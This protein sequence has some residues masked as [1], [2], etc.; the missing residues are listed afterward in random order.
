MG[1]VNRYDA[2]VVGGGH[3]GLVAAFYLARAGLKPIVL[4]R[5]HVTGGPC[6]P[7]EYFP[8]YRGAFTNS[9]GSLEP[10]IVRDMELERHGLKFVV[11]NPT[12]VHPF[13]GD[14][15]FIGWRDRERTDEV[16]ASFSKK[17]AVAYYQI[18]DFLNAFGAK[19]GV[20]LFKPPPSLHELVARMET[21]EDEANFSDIMFGSV[22]DFLDARLETE[23]IKALIALLAVMSN[24]VGPSTPG[25]P[26]QLLQRPMSLASNTV[27][28][29]HDPRQ[30]PLRGSTGLPLGGMGS[31]AR[32]MESALKEKGG[33]VRT[34]SAV[35]RI[36][37]R[38]GRVTGVALENGDEF[39]ADLVLSNLHPKTTLLGLT[40]R[41]FLPSKVTER[42]GRYVMRN[43]GFKVVLALDG[44]PRYA[45]AKTDEEAR[46]IGGCQFRIAPTMEYMDRGV[47]AARYGELHHYPM[48]W[49]LIPSVADPTMAP[50]GK[51]VMSVNIFHAPYH[52]RDGDWS[53]Q[54][55]VFG[56]RCID[57]LSQFMPN[58]KSLILQKRFWSPRDLESEFGLLEG[59]V[60]HGDMVP[61]KMFGFRPSPELAD[62]RTPINGLYHCGSGTWPGGTV[63]GLPGHN[64][65][66]QVL[67]DLQL[68]RDK[69]AAELE[70]RFAAAE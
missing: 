54:R 44:L 10:K 64:G 4:E 43:G 47:D 39:H 46:T 7:V 19:L 16:L 70:R 20:S 23:E 33:E 9:P 27:A 68:G 56:E 41:E 28:A 31:I 29:S 63:S 30:Q 5:R 6:G 61:G 34:H 26:C 50:P 13:Y 25:T 24:F 57:I 55:D 59:N 36:L 15:A 69:V 60:M 38:N 45:A 62:Y 35:A 8:G 32:A 14:R 11:A 58:L 1:S 52:L 51:H 49:G 22:K 18:F 17:D 42:L 3:N 21:R 66:H 67:A 65:S 12:V 37:A 40:P 2:I 48:M 53:T